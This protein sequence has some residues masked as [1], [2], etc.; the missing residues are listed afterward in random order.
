MKEL[1]KEEQRICIGCQECCKHVGFRIR[2][3]D[4]TEKLAY[5]EFYETRGF[6]VLK[7]QTDTIMV[8]VENRCPKLTQWG[9]KVYPNRPIA[10]RIYDGR[11][12]PAMA[13]FCKLP[14]EQ[15]KKDKKK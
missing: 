8:V 15:A 9:C 10:C 6:T 11:T 14:K 3:F 2:V 5:I 4:R 13:G 1:S 7:D 12:D